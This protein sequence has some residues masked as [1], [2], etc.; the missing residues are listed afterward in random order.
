MFEI[1]LQLAEIVGADKVDFFLTTPNGFLGGR[2]PEELLNSDNT[3]LLSLAQ[4]F[5]HPADVF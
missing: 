3:R 1:R 2:K 5:A 4:A